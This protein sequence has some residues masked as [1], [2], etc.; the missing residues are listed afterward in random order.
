MGG[1]VQPPVKLRAPRPEYTELARQAR[2]Q[3]V[4]V[5]QAIIDEE[6]WVTKV[7]V[8]KGLPMGLTEEA[9]KAVCRWRFEPATIDGEPVSVDS[10]LALN[11]GL[12]R[13]PR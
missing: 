3:G 2:I 12:S 13:K 10:T 5:V 11:F 4:V 7:K 1:N 9:L 6:G 8:S